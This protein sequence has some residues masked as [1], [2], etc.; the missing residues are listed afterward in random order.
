MTM[1][2]SQDFSRY[3]RGIRD[4]PQSV[5]REIAASGERVVGYVGNDVP[6]ALILASGAVPVRIRANPKFTPAVI[7]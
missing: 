5:A 1:H 2:T 7:P 6:V 4:E 3:L